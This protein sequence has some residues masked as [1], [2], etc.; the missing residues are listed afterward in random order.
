MSVNNADINYA[1]RPS[2]YFWPITRETHLIAAIKGERR[3]NAVRAA[4]ANNTANRLSDQYTVP[5]LAEQ[6]RRAL[7]AVH[8][9]YMGGEYL[10]NRQDTEVEIARINIDSTTSDVVCIYAK[11]GK[12]RIFYRVVD[13]YD[14]DTLGEKTTRSSKCPLTLKQLVTFFLRAWSLREVLGFNELDLDDAL[15]F[16]RPSSEFY[17]QFA[18]AIRAEI[19]E[20]YAADEHNDEEDED[21]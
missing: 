21:E 5:V 18:A 7:G 10:P 8:P 13:E 3:R 4:Y 12:D 11:A 14:G 17:P 20:W 1:F 2:S 19:A 6:D 16:T 15:R 9:S